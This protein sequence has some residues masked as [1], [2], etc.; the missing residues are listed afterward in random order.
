MS[1]PLLGVTVV[2]VASYLGHLGIACVLMVAVLIG[3]FDR[4]LRRS[5][6]ALNG[7]WF[8]GLFVGVILAVVVGADYGGVYVVCASLAFSVIATLW[9]LSRAFRQQRGRMP[10]PGPTR[11]PLLG[12]AAGVFFLVGVA[13]EMA[14]GNYGTAALFAIPGVVSRGLGYWRVHGGQ[15]GPR[16]SGPNADEVDE[17]RDS[18]RSQH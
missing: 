5:P 6:R 12:I 18:G 3:L 16:G 11:L 9:A 10:K 7:L 4:I 15:W 8:L 14:Y 1:G 2:R 17:R 13:F